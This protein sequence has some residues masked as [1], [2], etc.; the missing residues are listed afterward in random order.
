MVP[1]LQK[2]VFMIWCGPHLE[3]TAQKACV[4][5]VVLFIGGWGSL[6]MCQETNVTEGC[7]QVSD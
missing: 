6:S 4:N 1:T 2:C 5:F 7:E 3:V